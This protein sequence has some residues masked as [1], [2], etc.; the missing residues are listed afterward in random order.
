MPKVNAR[1]PLVHKHA[2]AQ[3]QAQAPQ[4]GASAAGGQVKRKRPE[5]SASAHKKPKQ[6]SQPQREQAQPR[7]T[8]HHQ[9][10]NRLTCISIVDKQAAAAL[11]T[12]LRADSGRAHGATLKSLTLAPHIEA[13][14]ATY[15]VTCQTMKCER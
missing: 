1:R 12:L 9:P 11:T 6:A 5:G 7:S 14:K 4:H 3:P 15:A 10:N 2:Q 8:A 13:K